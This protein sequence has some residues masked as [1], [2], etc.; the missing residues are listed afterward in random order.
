MFGL[1]CIV[2]PLA[3]N[4]F[5]IAS[6]LQVNNAAIVVN[7]HELQSKFSDGI[8]LIMS[9]WDEY[10]QANLSLCDGLGIYRFLIEFQR[11]CEPEKY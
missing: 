3:E 2:I 9:K 10:V 5:E 4:Q 11:L 7:S 1:P 6:I 8:D